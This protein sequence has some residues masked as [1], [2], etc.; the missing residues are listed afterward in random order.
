MLGFD[1]DWSAE[2]IYGKGMEEKMETMKDEK[3]GSAC[4]YVFRGDFRKCAEKRVYY[5]VEL[6]HTGEIVAYIDFDTTADLWVS[7]TKYMRQYWM[8]KA[9]AM[10][11]VMERLEVEKGIEVEACKTG[12]VALFNHS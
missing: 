5:L 2:E 7:V 9:Q 4:P 11:G 6:E 8:S 3:W 12:R 1:W 10:K